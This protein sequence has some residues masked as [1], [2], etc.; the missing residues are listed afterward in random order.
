MMRLA[1]VIAKVLQ[2]DESRITEDASPA[3]IETWDSF[4]GLILVSELE[5]VFKVKFTFQEV[6]AVKTV[7]DILDNLRN[8]GI[9]I[10][11]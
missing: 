6:N 3:M 1:P 10:D 4:N 7:K 11:V 5:T 9:E 8:R 2:V